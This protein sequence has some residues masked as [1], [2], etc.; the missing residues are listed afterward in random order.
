M[1]SPNNIN[2]CETKH[3]K[4]NIRFMHV[5]KKAEN[6]A[7]RDRRRRPLEPP[8]LK[9]KN[10]D[11]NYFIL[12]WLFPLSFFSCFGCFMVVHL[13]YL[14][15]FFGWMLNSPSFLPLVV[16]FVFFGVL[17]HTLNTSLTFDWHFFGSFI[18]IIQTFSVGGHGKGRCWRK[19]HSRSGVEIFFSFVQF[20]AGN[21]VKISRFW[22]LPA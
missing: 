15:F 4:F 22:Y 14:I 12:S 10:D 7:T 16:F 8:T 2:M 19:F 9:E 5:E 17:K 1:K 20:W 18:C 21:N 6:R 13:L 11:Y 3:F